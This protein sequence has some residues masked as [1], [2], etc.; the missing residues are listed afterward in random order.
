MTDRARRRKSVGPTDHAGSAFRERTGVQRAGCVFAR[1]APWPGVGP[2]FAPETHAT[3]NHPLTRDLRARKA[4]HSGTYR[5]RA[6]EDVLFRRSRG[7]PALRISS[8]AS[9]IS[10]LSR[11]PRELSRISPPVR[12]Q[13]RGVRLDSRCLSEIMVENCWGREMVM[14]VS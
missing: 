4:K 9:R 1:G 6:H 12:V 3:R 13:L 8:K 2:L 11:L 5:A 10:R 7:F 14:L